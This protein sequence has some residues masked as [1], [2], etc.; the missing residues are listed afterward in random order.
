MN[1]NK[2]S[3]HGSRLSRHRQPPHLLAP[4]QYVAGKV[5]R[6][7]AFSPMAAGKG[8]NVLPE[9]LKHGH[10]C[11]SVFFAG[12]HTGAMLEDLIAEDGVKPHS[13]SNQ[14]PH[15]HGHHLCRGCAQ[16]PQ[17]SLLE[18]GFQLAADEVTAMATRIRQ[19]LAGQDLVIVSGS[20]PDPVANGLY[21]EICTS[22]H[23]LAIPIWLIAMAR[24]WMKPCKG[25]ILPIL[26]SSQPRR[27]GQQPGLATGERTAHH[28]RPA[29]HRN[30]RGG[31]QI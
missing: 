28:R 6:S 14:G 10:H 3:V 25:P 20:V 31:G 5:T 17:G 21:A 19:T 4:T 26:P 2:G 9:F 7:A 22:R 18:H 13:H 16:R 30:S 12:G 23:E 1:G 29:T 24:P 27:I 8:I 15:A 11:D